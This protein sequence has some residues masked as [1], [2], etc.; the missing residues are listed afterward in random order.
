MS[1]NIFGF[2]TKN[3]PP[4][5]S[6]TNSKFII[7][8]N[9]LQTK[10]NKIGDTLSGNLNVG[11]NKITNLTDPISDNDAAN[12]GFVDSRVKQ[13]S[14]NT[15]LYVDTLHATKLDK[16]ITENLNMNGFSI[17]NVKT[18]ISTHDVVS[19]LYVQMTTVKHDINIE[20]LLKLGDTI[21]DLFL[22]Y[23]I[24]N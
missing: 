18:P 4:N 7:H 24:Q 14:I 20:N 10:V 22:K 8:S 16:N 23:R 17:T 9:Q 19:K 5:Q 2:R 13:E 21:S 12:K 3:I 6:L 11:G 15:K 1:V